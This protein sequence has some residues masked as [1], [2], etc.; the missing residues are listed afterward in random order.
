MTKP[1]NL[2]YLIFFTVLCLSLSAKASVVMGPQF[3]ITAK[4]T[5]VG[6]RSIVNASGKAVIEHFVEFVV[7]GFESGSSSKI[8]PGDIHA[9]KISAR[10]SSLFKKDDQ[11][12]IG[13]EFSSANT[14]TGP[15]EL[16]LFGP[17]KDKDGKTILEFFF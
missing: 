2:A 6:T 7:T 8:R 11:L 15:V 1:Y 4:V 10:H 12:I 17:V 14:P 16:R 3:F 13:V 5:D 9:V